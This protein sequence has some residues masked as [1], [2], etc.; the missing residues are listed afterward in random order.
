[1]R[2]LY[3]AYRWSWLTLTPWRN[4]MLCLFCM[5]PLVEIYLLVLV[6]G[7]LGGWT[8]LGS[9]FAAAIL[10]ACLFTWHR[11]DL[12]GRAAAVVSTGEFP[13]DELMEAIALAVACALLLTPGYVTDAIGFM[14]FWPKFR[15]RLIR[16][17]LEPVLGL[18]FFDE[19]YDIEPRHP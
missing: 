8:V 19:L 2:W 11:Y 9:V 4:W 6:Y 13:N 12:D 18:D 15:L 17:V 3:L 16:F 7:F 14:L 1:M 5:V 10:G